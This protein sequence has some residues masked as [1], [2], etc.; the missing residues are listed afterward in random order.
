M[1]RAKKAEAELAALR[2]A[3][4]RGKRPDTRTVEQQMLGY[5]A[6]SNEVEE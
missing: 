1:N 3:V 4:W 5:P 2:L 6:I